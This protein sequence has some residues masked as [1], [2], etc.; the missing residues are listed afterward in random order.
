MKTSAKPHILSGRSEDRCD[1]NYWEVV[2]LRRHFARL[3]IPITVRSDSGHQFSS[4]KFKHFAN[5]WSFNHVTSSTHFPNYNGKVE[6]AVKTVKALISNA[7]NDM[8]D[9]WPAILSH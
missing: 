7:F 9:P 5:E 6:N 3:G 2:H 4:E 8:R 1:S